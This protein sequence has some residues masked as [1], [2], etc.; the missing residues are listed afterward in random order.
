MLQ[1]HTKTRLAL[2]I[3]AAIA[4]AAPQAR[5]E[6]VV[7]AQALFDQAK[8]AMAAGDYAAACPKL[9]ESLRLQEALGTRL[10]LADCYEHEGRPASAWG[11]FLEVASRAHAA[12]QNQRAQVARQRAAALAPKLSNLVIDV[13]AAGRVAGL[14]VR[15]DAA[16]VGE[17]EWGT[18][19]P[20]DPGPHTISVSAP[21]R[22]SWSQAVTVP[23]GPAITRV[24]VPALE[25]L[26]VEGRPAPLEASK[27]S[28]PA[29]V[30]SRPSTPPPEPEPA[31]P[32][33]TQRFI[34]LAL[35]GAGLLG[36]GA[37][38]ALGLF[39]R[40]QFDRAKSESGL[41]AHDDSVNAVN[42]GNA[43]TIVAVAGGA[44]AL[45]GVVVW[46]SAPRAPAIV[47]TDGRQLLVQGSF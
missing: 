1:R 12:G 30:A 21:G 5:A 31:R 29:L 42:L 7:A 19:I 22:K 3:A 28:P 33:R 47:G 11:V 20:S 2:A 37:G 13:P 38:G 27:P 46:L 23:L 41:A 24:A 9:E 14:E 40:V 17:A 44:I 18:P 8:K 16:L 36:A 39:A 25:P 35:A 15:R 45:T 32:G 26:P 34:G 10:N 4:A 6:D 43:A